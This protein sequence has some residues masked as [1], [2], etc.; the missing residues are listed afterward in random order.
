MREYFVARA[1][2]HA[3]TTD[4]ERLRRILACAPLVPEITH[5]AG[6][7]LREEPDAEALAALERLGRSATIGQSEEYLGGNA[8]TLLYAAGANPSHGDWSGCASTTPSCEA[9]TYEQ[10]GSLAA[11]FG[12]PTWITQ[13]LRKPI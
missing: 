4:T 3:L 12:M 6:T 9:R 11:R 2:V 8:L 10:R 13:T 7:I 1:I 5:F